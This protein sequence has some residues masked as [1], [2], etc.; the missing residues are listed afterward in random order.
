M[1]FSSLFFSWATRLW[2]I[3]WKSRSFLNL[4]QVAEAC[5]RPH[6]MSAVACS[7]QLHCLKSK[8]RPEMAELCWALACRWA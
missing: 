1:S 5:S 2:C 3:L 6:A 4:S 7:D 8:A